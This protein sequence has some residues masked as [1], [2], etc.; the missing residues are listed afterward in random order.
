MSNNQTSDVGF[1]VPVGSPLIG[2]IISYGCIVDPNSP[3]PDGWLLCDGSAVSRATYDALF[4]VIGTLHGTGDG[5]HTF[6]LPDYRGRFQRGVDDGTGRDPDA[7][8]RKAAHTGGATGDSVASIQDRATGLPVGKD[9]TFITTSDNRHWH[10]VNHLP[11]SS[12]WYEI[13]GSH[14][15]RWNSNSVDS[16]SNG[17]HTHTIDGGGDEDTCPINLYVNMLIYYGVRA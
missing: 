16:S 10:T 8:S 13:A 11:T 5:V 9:N 17:E 15:A 3:P 14:Y 1:Q 12:S 4:K 7:S 6:N 2:S